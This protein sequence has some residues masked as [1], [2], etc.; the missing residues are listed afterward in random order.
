MDQTG[1]DPTAA[2]A[3][4]PAMRLSSLLLADHAQVREGLLFVSGGGVTAF[5]FSSF[6][7][8]LTC[9]VAAL[10]ELQGGSTGTDHGLELYL[11]DA[12]RH[13]YSTARSVIPIPPDAEPGWLVPRV[14][15]F[16]GA[17]LPS[18]GRYWIAVAL[19]DTL[20]G[21]VSFVAVGEG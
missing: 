3:P 4:P 8:R 13:V 7:G 14:A 5:R 21:R 9:H 10:L 12:E 16:S 19:D 20:L 15:D 18:P 17:E 11:Y 2:P 1:P 6:P